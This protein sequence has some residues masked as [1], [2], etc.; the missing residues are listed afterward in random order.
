MKSSFTL[1]ISG[2][3][4]SGK[5]TLVQGLCRRLLESN[6]AGSTHTHHDDPSDDA[7]IW[8]TATSRAVQ[9]VDVVELHLDDFYLVCQ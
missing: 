8:N 3:S 4:T 2:A 7:S 1:G 6:M 9:E 5:S